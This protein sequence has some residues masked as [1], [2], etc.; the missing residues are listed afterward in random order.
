M[1]KKNSFLTQH[2]KIVKKIMG[3]SGITTPRQTP[4]SSF[5]GGEQGDS[6]DMTA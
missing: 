4:A 6:E 2:P 1:S 3:S 5:Y